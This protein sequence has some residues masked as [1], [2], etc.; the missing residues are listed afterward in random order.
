MRLAIVTEAWPFQQAASDIFTLH[1][2]LLQTLTGLRRAGHTVDLIDPSR[3][4]LAPA[5]VL[6]MLRQVSRAQPR[7]DALL[8]RGA[9]DTLLI[10]SEGP[11]G[12]A[13]RRW[14]RHTGKP[15]SSLTTAAHVSH[16]HWPDRPYWLPAAW[17]TSWLNRFHAAASTVLTPTRADAHILQGR[18][19]HNL[20]V[21]HPGVDLQAYTP[22]GD[23]LASPGKLVFLWVHPEQPEHTPSPTQQATDLPTLLAHVVRCG[24]PGAVWL[25]AEGG[26]PA[27]L[28]AAYPQIR[29][30]EHLSSWAPSLRA[31]LY[32]SADVLLLP[33]R[34]EG[35]TPQCLQ[36]LACGTPIA[37]L[38]TLSRT[39]LLG[40]SQAG[41][42][43]DDVLVSALQALQ[44]PRGQARQLAQKHSQDEAVARLLAALA[45]Q[46]YAP[47]CV[48]PVAASR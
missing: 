2:G 23:T 9:Y 45:V 47:D 14:A 37:G 7:L 32:R 8:Q 17:L 4:G 36:A 33:D 31:S 11:L 19:L 10:A 3:I 27:G 38:A 39:D 15:F 48:T 40:H 35:H 5:P 20:K 24:L 21:W 6:E 16:P 18:G 46:T 42:L 34:C 25:A 29:M 13:A 43:G 12:W 26:L 30:F 1:D 22:H 28:Q 41:V 44:I